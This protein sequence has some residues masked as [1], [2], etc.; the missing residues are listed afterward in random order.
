M[1]DTA[2]DFT[3]AAADEANVNV[4]T[5]RIDGPII[6][7]GTDEENIRQA[8]REWEQGKGGH[9]DA[10]LEQRAPVVE[11]KYDGREHGTKTLQE[12]TTDLSNA[13]FEEH[14]DTRLAAEL[15]KTTSAQMREWIKDPDVVRNI[16]PDWNEAEIS[17]YVRT[18]EEPPRKLNL[19]DHKGALVEPL[20]DSE[21]IRADQA[22]DPREAAK[23]L[24]AFREADAAYRQRP[25]SWKRRH[26]P[27]PSRRPHQSRR[28]RRRL[29]ML[30][31]L[32]SELSS[33]RSSATFNRRPLSSNSAPTSERATT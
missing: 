6:T 28:P 3:A 2:E 9:D 23:Q 19:I 11:R 32:T 31:W 22:L 16:R 29:K 4:V 17:H 30:L 24:K 26:R 27:K 8:T 10:F 14:A 20:R 13:H 15:G 7:G 18:G 12:A 21:K 5:R 33:R 25:S 1:S